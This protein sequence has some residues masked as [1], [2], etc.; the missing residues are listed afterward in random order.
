[1][2]WDKV[3]LVNLDADNVTAPTFP[4]QLARD[5]LHWESWQAGSNKYAAYRGS[6]NTGT[7]GRVGCSAADFRELGGYDQESGVVGSGNQDIDLLDRLKAGRRASNGSAY[8]K[9][10]RGYTNVGLA[11]PNS[12]D[13]KVDRNWAKIAF[14]APAEKLKKMVGLQQP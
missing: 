8:T 6:S 1:M 5:L 7:V 2:P 11:I 12:K 13:W 10:L 9:H 4:F 3:V 14:C